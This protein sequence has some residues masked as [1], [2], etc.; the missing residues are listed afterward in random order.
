M[1]AT[2]APV[3][4]SALE[5]FLVSLRLGLTSFGGPIAHL[6]YFEREFVQ[7][8]RWLAAE[9]Y[10]GIVGL[11]QA[12]PGPASSQ[13]NFLV[14][15]QRA[16]FLGG[17][18]SFLGFTLPSAAIMLLAALYL[19]H[20]SAQPFLLHGLKL[21]AAVVVAQAVWHMAVRLCTDRM[22]RILAAVVF[23]ITLLFGGMLTQLGVLLLGGLAGWFLLKNATLPVLETG[24]VISARAALRC[25]VTGILLLVALPMMAALQTGGVHILLADTFYRAGALVFGGGHV[26]LP[27]LHAT[28]GI[29]D[30]N[31][32]ALYGVAQALPGPLFTIAAGLGAAMMPFTPVLG[33]V[34]GLFFIFLP[35]MLFAL[36]GFY[37][38]QGIAQ[39]S[40]AAGVLAGINAAVVGLLAS[41]F[42]MPV[43]TSAYTHWADLV[44]VVAGFALLQKYRLPPVIVVGLSVLFAF[45]LGWL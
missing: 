26:V 44:W 33:G 21:A 5:C 28:A 39:N 35:G 31:F 9:S 23:L 43:M 37:Y 42:V 38:W 22:R 41:A 45:A 20:L 15:L 1:T 7:T 19:D 2:T 16:G 30:E 27:L 10:A 6:G 12:L 11:C 3:R 25:L 17:L 4:A 34:L 36:A 14:G 40:K 24:A 32:M 13:V 18:L 8:R 29:A